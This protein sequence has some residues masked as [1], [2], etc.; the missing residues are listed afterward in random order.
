MR[1]ARRIQVSCCLLDQ[2]L[3]SR[4]DDRGN[5]FKGI[6]SDAPEDMRVIGVDVFDGLT[7]TLVV[8]SETFDELLEGECPPLF[9]PTFTEHYNE[10]AA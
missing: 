8:E 4:S 5:L 9:A 2:I 6:T 7:I 1:R 10:A 3:T